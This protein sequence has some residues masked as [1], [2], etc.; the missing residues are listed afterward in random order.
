MVAIA[1]LSMSSSV[2]ADIATIISAN[3]TSNGVI[4]GP[5]SPNVSDLTINGAAAGTGNVIN[6]QIDVRFTYSNLD[7]DGDASAN[8]SVTFTL[9]QAGTGL[10]LIDQGFDTG[11]GSL[12]GSTATVIDVVGTTTDSGDNIVFD[13]FIGAGLGAGG[14]GAVSV[15]RNAD[16]NGV[17]IALSTTANG[18]F[19]FVQGFEDFAAT[20]AVVFDNSGGTAGSL[21]ARSYDLQFSTVAVPEPSSLAVLGLLSGLVA[22]RR[23]K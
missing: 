22:L 2:N 4:D 3:V 18:S 11:F 20:S 19:Q 14:G 5:N 13:G 17:N 9:R 6:D 7:L 12:N 8:D 21:V 15:D 1:A 23:R 16:V 10:R